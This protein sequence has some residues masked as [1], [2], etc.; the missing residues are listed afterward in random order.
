VVSRVEILTVPAGWEDDSLTDHF[1]LRVHWNVNGVRSTARGTTNKGV[2]IRRSPASVADVRFG[3]SFWIGVTSVSGNH[4]E[5]LFESSDFSVWNVVDVETTIVDEFSLWSTVSDLRNTVESTVLS[6]EEHNSGPVVRQVLHERAGRAGRQFG[7]IMV[8]A[9]GDFERVTT[10]D[11]V[12][13]WGV[14][15]SWVHNWVDTVDDQ[16]RTRKSKHVL[17]GSVLSE[18]HG[19]SDG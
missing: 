11:L 1:A 3:D 8:G 12:Q 2:L 7:E 5:S 19:S 13:M 16:L 6:F 9:H 14:N 10:D 17:R 18:K 4:S 15:L